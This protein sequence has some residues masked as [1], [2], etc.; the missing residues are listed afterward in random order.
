[1]TKKYPGGSEKGHN[2]KFVGRFHKKS[3]R[4]KR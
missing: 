4:I 1:M 2:S 3:K